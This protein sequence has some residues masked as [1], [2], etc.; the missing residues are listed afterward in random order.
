MQSIKLSVVIITFNEE[1][2]IERCLSSL[3]DIADE[4]VVVDSYSTDRTE[5]ICRDY[6]VKFIKNKFQGHIEQKNFA[7]QHASFRH[8]LSIDADEALSPELLQSIAALKKNWKFNAYAVNR[9]TNYCGKWIRHG[10]WYPDRKVRLFVNGTGKWGGEN[11]H[12][13]FLPD[14]P[15]STGKLKGDLLHYSYY[16]IEGHIDQVN[17]FT[18]VG[19]LSALRAGRRANRLMLLYKP[20]YKFIR[21]YFFMFGFLD[22]YSGFIIARISSHATFL[23]YAK[24]M[25]LQKNS[26]PRD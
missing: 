19:A 25:E 8:V 18:T 23:K 5:E 11:P 20:F 12:D 14:V 7:L 22:G 13:Q 1:R 10:S 17:K 4:M 26:A 15:S 9:L 2:N 6:G 16:S 24:L 21:D 3:K